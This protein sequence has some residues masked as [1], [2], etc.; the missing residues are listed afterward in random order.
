VLAFDGRPPTGLD[1]AI[2]VVPQVQGGLADRLS[3]AFAAIEGRGVLI[4]MDTP[5]ISSELVERALA[6]LDRPDDAVVGPGEDGGFWLVGFTRSAPGAFGGVPMSSPTTRAALC[7]RL[8]ELGLRVTTLPSLRDVDD[9][10]D[11]VAVAR[12]APTTR[13]ATAFRLLDPRPP[14]PVA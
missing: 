2:E 6:C 10:E 8:G 4:G 1:P 5:Q 13:F 11:A 12:A 7:R 3:G 14:A 9:Y